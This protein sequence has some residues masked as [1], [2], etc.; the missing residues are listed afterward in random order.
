[1]TVVVC[2]ACATGVLHAFFPHTLPF[3]KVW[4]GMVVGSGVGVLAGA[5]WQLREK[6]RRPQTSGWLLVYTVGIAGVFSVLVV[7]VLVPQMRAEE[8]LR[9]RV[10]S[11]SP[12]TLEWILLRK[13]GSDV[14]KMDGEALARFC[15][16]TRTA[17]LFYPS[18]EGP[19]AE[20]QMSMLMRDSEV[21]DLRAWVPVWHPDD[22]SLTFMGPR[23]ETEILLRG[24][25]EWLHS[26][27]Q[28][29]ETPPAK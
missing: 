26:A 28:Q 29:V 25:R 19:L 23:F 6:A 16:L 4:S 15:Q 18:G 21:V 22:L 1:M 27:G 14:I 10:R 13:Q 5:A 11:L 2:A 24:G 12:Q 17:Q 9:V 7:S 3:F 20:Y 8:A